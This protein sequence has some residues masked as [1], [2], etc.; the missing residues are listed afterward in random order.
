MD[1]IV[2]EGGRRL[3][4][5]IR[6]S[7][8]KNA[9][10]PLMCAALLTDEP[11][12]LRNVPDLM[13]VRTIA[14]LLRTMGATV[15]LE[16]GTAVVDAARL[17]RPEAPY[18]LVKTMRASILVLGPLVARMG[19]ARVSLPGGCAIGERPINLHLKGLEALGARIRLAGG[20]VEAEAP[21]LKGERIYLDTPTVTGTENLMMAAVLAEGRTTIKNA[22]REPEVVDLAALLVKMGARIE[23]AGSD[24]VTVEGTSRLRGAEHTVMPD[25][26]E[27]GTL[28]VAAGVT[29]GEL[30][31]DEARFEHLEAPI[32]KFREA[33]LEIT[34]DSGGIRVRGGRPIRAVDVKTLPFP[35][36]PTDL[37]AQMMVLMALSGGLSVITETVF[38]N[39]FMHV[40]ELRRM[41]AQITTQGNRAII[42]GVARL[43]G[44]PVMASDLRA[45]AALV[46]AGL[47]AEGT[48]EVHR[49]YHLDRGYERLEQKLAAVG[50]AI[51]RVPA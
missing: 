43:D 18:E 21:R 36:F 31:L 34:V 14:R 3:A 16:A 4:G 51:R 38:E 13:D 1:K 20:Y 7:G 50:A 12:V 41:G 8:A 39:R 6:V 10:L 46:L 42:R 45:S 17:E 25:R 24:I 22:A 48:T 5:R 28:M 47:A 37:Q 2:I 35:G 26:I 23:G 30:I 44:A 15:T 9:A 19:R 11:V 49:I 40:P 33:G 29:G 32:A 27:A